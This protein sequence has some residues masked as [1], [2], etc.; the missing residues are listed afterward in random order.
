MDHVMIV[1]DVAMLTAPLRRPTTPQGQELRGA[2]EALEPV[3]VEVNIETV[4][5]QTRRN[6]VEDAPQDEAAA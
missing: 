5:N 4:T 2:E 3:I 6:A 1:D